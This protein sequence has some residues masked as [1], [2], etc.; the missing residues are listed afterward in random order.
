MA[1]VGEGQMIYRC[2]NNAVA[3]HLNTPFCSMSPRFCISESSVSRVTKLQEI[4]TYL[5]RR[6]S[7]GKP[8]LSHSGYFQFCYNI[9]FCVKCCYHVLNYFSSLLRNNSSQQLTLLIDIRNGTKLDCENSN[10]QFLNNF[11]RYS[12]EQY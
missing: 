11:W 3:A 12:N 10:Q 5:Q 7:Y 8:Q 1:R 6:Q 2:A 4:F 9:F